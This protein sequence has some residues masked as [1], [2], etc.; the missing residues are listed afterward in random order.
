MELIGTG[1]VNIL[2]DHFKFIKNSYLFEQ[3]KYIGN[4]FEY[5]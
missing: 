5:I 4:I 3:F 2:L 1:M